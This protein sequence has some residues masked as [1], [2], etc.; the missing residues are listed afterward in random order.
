MLTL[1][2]GF[3]LPRVSGS[4]GV[5]AFTSPNAITPLLKWDDDRLITTYENSRGLSNLSFFLAPQIEVIPEW[6]NISGYIQYRIERMKGTG[7][8]LRNHGWSGNASLQLAHW[9][10]VLS[11]QYVKAER[12]LW[13]EKISWGEDINI[14][15]LS[16]NW[17]DW[18]FGAGVIMPFGRY[19]QGSRQI[20]K[21]NRNE[22]HMRLDMRMCY[23][24]ISYNLQWGRH[25]QSARKLTDVN[26]DADHST[27]G[28][29]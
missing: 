24:S 14:I 17:R 6:L 29:R 13:G 21:Y 25:K 20:S 11:G 3:S 23:L 19:D 22:Q 1:R 5:R 7:Y 16:Y 9:G 12:D 27:A 15:D 10:F 18:Q 4:F 8:S 2:Y 28:G 26:A